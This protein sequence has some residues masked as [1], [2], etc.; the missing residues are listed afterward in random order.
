LIG[1]A[2]AV[3]FAGKWSYSL[4]GDIGGFGVGSDL[5]WQVLTTVRRQNTDRFGWYLGYRAIGFDYEDGRGRNYQR[6]DLTHQGP[7][8]GITISS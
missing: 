2:Y 7:L 8:A 3:P 6:Y 4:R 1:L 5:T